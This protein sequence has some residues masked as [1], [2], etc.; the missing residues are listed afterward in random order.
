M[1]VQV[2]TQTPSVKKG[3]PLEI[4]FRVRCVTP[5]STLYACLEID[6]ATSNLEDC[7]SCTSSGPPN[8]KP[9]LSCLLTRLVP[10]LRTLRETP[11]SPRETP[12]R[13][14]PETA[15]S[16]VRGTDHGAT[17]PTKLRN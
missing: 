11:F 10:E 4:E 16:P 6:A 1:G 14:P 17:C 13:I 7:A 2:E 5:G 15:T 12:G 9:N 8:T 3:R